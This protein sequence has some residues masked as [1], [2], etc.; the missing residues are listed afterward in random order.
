MQATQQTSSCMQKCSVVL[1]L[2]NWRLTAV[3]MGCAVEQ[4]GRQ[5]RPQHSWTTVQRS[6]V[7]GAL[8]CRWQAAGNAD[9]G[10]GDSA[11][12]AVAARTIKR[13]HSWQS[14]RWPYI[15]CSRPS[16]NAARDSSALKGQQPRRRHSMPAS[17]AAQSAAAADPADLVTS[18]VRAG[19]LP[20]R[21]A[22]ARAAAAHRCRCCSSCCSQ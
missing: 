14:G 22:A 17:A 19:Q 15:A 5:R 16:D 3:D 4:Q 7:E 8:L 12:T 10:G 9:V 11:L 21:R 1:L 13:R 2:L 6:I 20:P 18:F